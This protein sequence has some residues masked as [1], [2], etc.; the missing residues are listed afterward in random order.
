MSQLIREGNSV[1]DLP[2]SGDWVFFIGG[3]VGAISVLRQEVLL[4]Q[5]RISED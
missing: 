2:I 3:I 4:E 5:Q 1:G